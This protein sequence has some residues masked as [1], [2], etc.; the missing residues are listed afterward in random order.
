MMKTRDKYGFKVFNEQGIGFY[1]WFSGNSVKITDNKEGKLPL[2]LN[3]IYTVQLFLGFYTAYGISQNMA[4]KYGLQFI[5]LT[6][7][8]WKNKEKP[9]RDF[10]KKIIKR[11]WQ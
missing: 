1:R 8:D 2:N 11:L 5:Q 9:V 10:F 7:Q 6:E 4:K 3:R